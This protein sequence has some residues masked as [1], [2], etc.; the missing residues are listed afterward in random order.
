MFH[1]HSKVY[2]H[3]TS[4]IHLKTTVITGA[5]IGKH[6]THFIL[7]EKADGG[8]VQLRFSLPIDNLCYYYCHLSLCKNFKEMIPA[9]GVVR[10][11]I[12][13]LISKCVL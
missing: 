4:Q 10:L 5:L 13:V 1:F 2:W 12:I 8:G 11:L 3:C 6:L 7:N 9:F